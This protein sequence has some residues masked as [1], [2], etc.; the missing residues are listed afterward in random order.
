[1]SELSLCAILYFLAWDISLK[2]SWKLGLLKQISVNLVFQGR[3]ISIKV[4]FCVCVCVCVCVCERERIL[5][6][7]FYHNFAF[8]LLLCFVFCS[9]QNTVVFCKLFKV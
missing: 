3:S 4:L 6:Q 7:I 9:L 1:M 2:K 5:A 8:L